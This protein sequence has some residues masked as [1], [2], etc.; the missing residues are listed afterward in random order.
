MQTTANSTSDPARASAIS[1]AGLVAALVLCAALG[2][3][4]YAWS[5][6]R[7]SATALPGHYTI[8]MTDY[9]F[10][11]SHMTWH[12]GERVTL[13]LVNRSEGHP[14]K[15]HEFMMGREP[16]QERTVFGPEQADGYRVPFFQG[17]DIQVEGGH[18]LSMLMPGGARLSGA[19]EGIMVMPEGTGMAHG[20]E[21]MNQPMQAPAAGDSRDMQQMG[22]HAQAPV[23][24]DMHETP[25]MEGH[26]Q[27]P[28]SGDAHR[29]EEMGEHAKA[30][31]AG[32][33]PGMEGHADAPGGGDAHDMPMPGAGEMRGTPAMQGM[34]DMEH[35]HGGH[36]GFMPVLEPVGWLGI[37]FTVPDKPGT[38]S[39]GCF[40]QSGQHFANG[41]QGTVTILAGTE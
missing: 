4:A 34:E 21:G 32:D 23:G 40:Q 33:M 37:S 16:A 12:V 22:E 13:T 19:T 2:I 15:P 35:M 26:A 38:W 36:E 5:T 29:M 3:G 17:V 31:A 1:G 18:G 30:P 39:Y 41:M 9:R 20:M 14:G 27:A 8:E 11:P 7:A 28:E 24:G 6:T 10:S 25:G